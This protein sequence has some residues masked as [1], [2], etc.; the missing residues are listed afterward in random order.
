MRRL[1]LRERGTQV[2]PTFPSSPE[3]PAKWMCTQRLAQLLL[4]AQHQ[5]DAKILRHPSFLPKA[6]LA[7]LRPF[8]VPTKCLALF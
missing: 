4:R 1:A 8:A 5:E 6:N 2:S 3:G 7:P